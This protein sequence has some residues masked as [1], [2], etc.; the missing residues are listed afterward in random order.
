MSRPSADPRDE[1]LD[2]VDEHDHVIGQAHRG[3]VY[4]ERL[5]HRGVF[6]LVRDEDDRIFVHRRAAGKLAYPSRYDM[7]VGGAVSA[8]ESYDQAAYREAVEE[9]GVRGLPAVPVPLLKSRYE[10]P[11]H[12]WWCAVY[13]VRCGPPV[14]PPVDEVEWHAFL[15]EAEL[16]RRLTEWAWA[17]D[18]LVAYRRL[19]LAA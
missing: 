3:R 9:L 1:L 14:D 5:C 8:G 2:V 6:V 11:E 7:F 15:S 19:R 18:S 13:S 10:S 12:D 16:A 17:P 4:A